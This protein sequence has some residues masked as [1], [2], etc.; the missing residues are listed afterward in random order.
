MDK[1]IKQVPSPYF[2]YPDGTPGRN[3]HKPLAVVMH[4]AEGSLPGI[5]A[6]FVSPQNSGSSTHYAIG[7]KGEIHQYVREEDAA[8]GNGI[9]KKP[10]WPLLVQNVN[11]NLYTISI[12]H[13]GYTGEPWTEEMLESDVW[14]LKRICQRWSIAMDRA[15]IIGHYQLDSVNRARCPGTGLPWDRLI[16]E[17]AVM[18]PKD[19]QILE[20]QA[21]V[22][23]LKLEV[24]NLQSQVQDQLQALQEE[25]QRAAQ[26]QTRLSSIGRLVKS[27]N[28]PQVYL[29]K[30]G[31]LYPIDSADTLDL[32]YSASLVETVPAAELAALPQGIAI[33][34]V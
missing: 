31:T 6:W 9:V 24:Q 27:A 30:S 10:T 22:K 17:L 29:L 2:G 8:W 1:E 33:H 28:A 34:I 12:E 21:Q 18:D 14:L 3:G 20:L 13:E 16:A 19:K 25:Q 4:I 15:H 26:L 23:D 7:K 32:L 5:D 11:P